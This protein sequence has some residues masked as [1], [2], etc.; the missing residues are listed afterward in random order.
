MEV[1]VYDH[2]HVLRGETQRTHGVDEVPVVAGEHLLPHGPAVLVAHP[3]LHEEDVVAP[4][5]EH[6]VQA[7][8]DAVLG[9]N[10]L[11]PHD[12]FPHHPR[13]QSEDCAAVEPDEAVAQDRNLEF[14]DAVACRGHRRPPY[15][16]SERRATAVA[17]AGGSPAWAPGRFDRAQGPW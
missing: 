15:G 16:V 7:K 4:A 17:P 10:R 1:R 8:A 12:R 9:V 11:G 5:H 3:R 13:D 2:G 6:A 14:A